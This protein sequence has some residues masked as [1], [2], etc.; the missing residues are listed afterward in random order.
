MSNKAKA[1]VVF[2]YLEVLA[3]L[4]DYYHFKKTNQSGFSYES[5]SQD[6]EFNSRSFLRMMV[7]GK[8]KITPK[9]CDAFANQAFATKKEK[10]YFALLVKYSQA[11]NLKVR[12]ECSHKMMQMVRVEMGTQIQGST[13]SF[14]SRPLLPRLLAIL[15]FTDLI[16]TTSFCAKILRETSE[17]IQ[18]AFLSLEKM[19]LIEKGP[20]YQ[21][22]QT[23][24]AKTDIFSV[25]DEFGNLNLMQFHEE[26]LK[27]AIA[28]FQQPKDL[29]RYRSLLL[30]MDA[31]GLK[32]FH[33]VLD[34][35]AESQMHN[36]NSKKAE[37]KRMFQ[38]NFNVYSVSE[39][40][41]P[42]KIDTL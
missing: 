31:E 40:L 17:N 10:D 36:Y 42:E 41:E 19:D 9:F 3:F 23:W 34:E 1:P 5:W 7:T 25:P 13:H 22:E 38:F 16:A 8:K 20:L 6:L 11:G 39:P 12:T 18:T 33:E 15:S 27:D 30:P 2:E 37:G 28:A 32:K 21:G 35:F 29:R 4:K 24:S 14:I 26:S